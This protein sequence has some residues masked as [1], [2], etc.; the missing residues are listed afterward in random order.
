ML[1]MTDLRVTSIHGNKFMAR[2]TTPHNQQRA[3]STTGSTAITAPT[4]LSTDRSKALALPDA[5]PR[6]RQGCGL[7]VKLFI[8]L[9]FSN[10]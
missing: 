1:S 3:G 9:I 4:D 6:S 5:T 7:C 8:K 2:G 10:L